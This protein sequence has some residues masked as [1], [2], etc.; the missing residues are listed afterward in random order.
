MS[1]GT[2]VESISPEVTS[3]SRS[4]KGSKV[5]SYWQASKSVT[6][7]ISTLAVK[8]SPVVTSAGALI[9]TIEVPGGNE[10]VV[11]LQE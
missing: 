7:L 11:K 2:V 1:T 6:L 9:L 3:S 5:T 8:S 4:T 10:P